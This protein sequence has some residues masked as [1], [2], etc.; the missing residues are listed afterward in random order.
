MTGTQTTSGLI[1]ANSPQELALR[2]RLDEA[3]KG[4]MQA[5][6][7]DAEGNAKTNTGADFLGR[8]GPTMTNAIQRGFSDRQ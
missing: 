1:N 2:Q 4:A 5:M 8:L 7:Q 6:G 3:K